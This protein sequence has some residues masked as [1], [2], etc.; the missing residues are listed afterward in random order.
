MSQINTINAIMEKDMLL[1]FYTCSINSHFANSLSCTRTER[2]QSHFL[3]SSGRNA[4]ESTV[5]HTGIDQSMVIGSENVFP[6]LNYSVIPSSGRSGGVQKPIQHKR[7]IAHQGIREPAA[8]PLTSP[9][10]FFLNITG[11]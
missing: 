9:T 6:L 2:N 4:P 11:D 3:P 1:L 7:C 10:F 5:A 8:G